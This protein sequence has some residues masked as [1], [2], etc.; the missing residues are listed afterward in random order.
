MNAFGQRGGRKYL[1]KRNRLAKLLRKFLVSGTIAVFLA[2]IGLGLAN[3]NMLPETGLLDAVVQQPVTADQFKP[4]Q[5]IGII[6]THLLIGDG[7]F[8]GTPENDLIL[9]SIGADF[10]DGLGGNDCILGGDQAD[11]LYGDSPGEPQ[12]V[13]DEF[14][15]SSYSNNDGTTSWMGDWLEIGESDGPGLGDV[16]IEVSQGRGIFTLPAN[17]DTYIESGNPNDNFGTVDVLEVRAR[18]NDHRQA[19]YRFDLSQIPVGANIISANVFFFVTDQDNYPVNIHRITDDWGEYSTTWNDANNI[20]DP[21]PVASFIPAYRRQY[22]SADLSSLMQ[23]WVNGTQPNYGVMLIGT[24]DNLSK[25][26]SRENSAARQPYLQ[27]EISIGGGTYRASADQDTYLELRQPN[28]NYGTA[29]ELTVRARVDDQKRAMY[30]FD[31]SQ[32]PAGSNIISAHAHFFV[33]DPSQ[34]SVVVYRIMNSWGENSATWNNASDIFDPIPV[35]SFIPAVRN[36]YVSADISGL[37]QGWVN[38]V[39]SNDGL[40]LIGTSNNQTQYASKESNFAR[41][42]YLEIVITMGGSAQALRIQNVSKGAQ[43][44]VDLCTSISATLEF[45]YL[46]QGLDDANDYVM[47]EISSD[48]GFS[49]TPLASILGPIND[50]Q[51]QFLSYDISAYISCSNAIRFVSSPQL[52]MDERVYIDNIQISYQSMSSTGGNDVLIGGAGDDYLN[53]G[54]GED[55]CYGGG[56]VNT[57]VNC[58]VIFDP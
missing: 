4:P 18:S 27:V 55:I 2:Q 40:M 31:L 14:N 6:P 21:T 7:S 34:A 47:I 10:V 5:C 3:S 51:M 15:A 29:D 52:G 43:R 56:G 25:Y 19:I 48:G 9:G 57:F 50:T 49:W 1:L 8:T 16:N 46:R 39:Y 24:F 22:V 13:R 12:S 26:A 28:S 33:T 35:S 41:H 45:Y 23:D 11:Q 44:S 37:V 30:R 42:P 17:Q 20:Y 38:R 53:G 58:E 54:G 32:I 36:Q